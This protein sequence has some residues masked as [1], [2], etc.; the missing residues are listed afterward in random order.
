MLLGIVPT[1]SQESVIVEPVGTITLELVEQPG[2]DWLPFGR[3]SS[4]V[5]R[6]EGVSVGPG[7]P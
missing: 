3:L 4:P 5:W 6:I 1:A 7:A 2:P